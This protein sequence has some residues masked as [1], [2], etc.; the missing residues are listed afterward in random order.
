M[1]AGLTA[2]GDPR[3]EVCGR[4]V[5]DRPPEWTA[6][7]SRVGTR[8]L[9]PADAGYARMSQA[10]NRLFD[11]RRPAGVVRCA[12]LDDVRA[13]VDFG[14]SSGLRV[15]ARSGGHSYPGYSTPEDGLVIDLRDMAGIRLDRRGV[16]EIGAGAR[17]IEVYAALARVGRCVPGG[18][19]ASLGIAGLTLGGG[20]G[21]L[22][23]AFGLT[24]DRLVAARVVTPGGRVVLASGQ[25][26]P[27]LFWALRGGGGGNFGIVTTLWL[28]T[29]PLRELAVFELHFPDAASPAVFAAWQD[30]IPGAPDEMW[31]RMLITGG[32][33]AS[34]TI[35]GC[36][37][38]SSATAGRHLAEL[39]R[40]SGTQPAS[41][42]V[43]D[44]AF[45]D[46][47]RYFADCS[48]RSVRQC[49]E[50]EASGQAFVASSRVQ[51]RRADPTGVCALL[52]GRPRL[53][54]LFEPL[55]GAVARTPV[56]ATAFPHR[57]ALATAQVFAPAGAGVEAEV[58]TVQHELAE[59]I[60]TGAYINYLDPGQ[61]DWA[62]ASYGP[63]LAR[64]RAIARRW[65]PHS[66]LGFPQG[67]AS[68]P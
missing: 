29:E 36:F 28:R 13:S 58:A 67:L 38:G 8:L 21:V 11:G 64:L 62:Q 26:E 3:T 30:W 68:C 47:M 48:D 19:C 54:L 49:R 60:G 40:R 65:D 14:V 15:A 22:D 1:A 4:P 20:M 2:C 35:Q 66:V 42:T 57:D 61:Q 45:L 7:R 41:Q 16:A 52:D 59:M 51:Q 6:L 46:A 63:N 39:I 27:E 12:G 53:T 33:P 50:A 18:T 32:T 37:L 17:L 43:W 56:S 24:C 10:Y 5:V 44:A 31:A 55:G 34:S 9:L 25:S 23:R